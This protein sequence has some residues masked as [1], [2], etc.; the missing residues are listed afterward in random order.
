M[1]FPIFIV[2][3]EN[4]NQSCDENKITHKYLIIHP[5]Y[6]KIARFFNQ[7]GVI[8]TLIFKKMEIKY[9]YTSNFFIQYKIPP[10]VGA[11]ERHRDSGLGVDELQVHFVP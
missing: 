7:T 9:E 6:L 5:F 8:I 1:S 10:Q 3:P 11:I 2:I 4:I